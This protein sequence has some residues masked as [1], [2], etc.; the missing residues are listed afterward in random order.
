MKNP[1][2]IILRKLT[3]EKSWWGKKIME[4]KQFAKHLGDDD[5]I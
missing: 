5:R 1:S 2:K 4:A 3:K